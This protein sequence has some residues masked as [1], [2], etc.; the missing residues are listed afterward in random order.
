MLLDIDDTLLCAGSTPTKYNV[1]YT[2]AEAIPTIKGADL[3]FLWLRP[4]VHLFLSVVS[5]WYKLGV[6]SAATDVYVST[7]MQRLDPHQIY[8]GRRRFTRRH[9][10]MLIRNGT[11]VSTED[12]APKSATGQ[13]LGT[14]CGYGKNLALILPHLATNTTAARG[15]RSNHIQL[16][17]KRA[18]LERLDDLMPDL[19]RV[20]LLD[21]EQLSFFHQPDNGLLAVP[22]KPRAAVHGKGNEKIVNVSNPIPVTT[23]AESRSSRCTANSSAGSIRNCE[24]SSVDGAE[25]SDRTLLDL[26]PL[27]EALA[28]VRDVRQVLRHQP[29]VQM[30]N[31]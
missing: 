4:H 13:V 30:E 10:T 20:V 19:S 24:N 29:H 14:H 9:C 18:S 28:H 7:V 15:S 17:L 23:A 21:N 31:S 1:P 25:D 16:G 12:T 8:F 22:Y 26:L 2:F 27:L 5:Q 11:T 3:I 6:F